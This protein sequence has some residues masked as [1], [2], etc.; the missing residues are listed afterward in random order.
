M[1]E[2]LI[3]LRSDHLRIQ[4]DLE[5]YPYQ[6][7]VSNAIISALLDNLRITAGASEEDVRRLKQVEVAIEQSRQCIAEGALVTLSNG[8][9][10]P[11]Q[12]IQI[13][14]DVVTYDGNKQRV[15]KVE[16]KWSTGEK[17]C[18]E[19]STSKGKHLIATA[20]HRF[21]TPDG[22][23]SINT[24]LARHKDVKF[25]CHRNNPR[26]I[27]GISNRSEF[28][29]LNDPELAK[30]LGYFADGY[31]AVRQTPKFTNNNLDYINEF[32][33]LVFKRFG[34]ATNQRAKGNGYDLHITDGSHAT[35]NNSFINFLREEGLYNKLKPERMVPDKIFDFDKESLALFLNRLIAADGW[36]TNGDHSEIGI[37]ANS[38]YHASQIVSLLSKF[39]VVSHLDIA[40]G[41]KNTKDFYKVRVADYRSLDRL[42]SSIGMV[43]GKEDKC[44]K[45]LDYIKSAKAKKSYVE[46][47]IFWDFITDISPVGRLPTYDIS[48]ADHHNYVANNLVVHNS[49][50]TY[51]VGH[52]CEF[53]LTFLPTLFGRPI[54]IGIFAAQLDQ[55]KISYNILRNGIRK[56]KGMMMI[57]EDEE[58]HIA[59]E[60][61]AR[62]LVLPDGS[63]IIV[64]P[65][66]KISQIEGSTLDLIII[67][68]AQVANDEIVKHSIWPMGK[69]NNAPRVYIGKAGTQINHYYRLCQKNESIKVYFDEVV[70]QRRETYDKTK[71]ARH[72]IYE[73]SV[74]EDIEKQ[75]IDADEIQR[76]Y[77]GK[78]QIGTGQ[79]ITLEELTELES[80]RGLTFHFQKGECFAGIDTA[81][82]PDETWCTILHSTGRMI[83]RVLPDGKTKEYLRERRLLNW[84]VLK[85]ENYQNQFDTLKAFLANYNVIAVAID[86]TGQGDFMGDLFENSTEWTDENSGLYRVKFSAMTKDIMYKN[87]KVSIKQ[88]LLDFPK[89]DS[90]IGEKFREQ[91]LDL[92]QEY[93]G[94]LLSVHHP[95]NAGAHDDAPDSL[96]LAD[97]A[98]AKWY[99]GNEPQLMTVSTSKREIDIEER[100]DNMIK[101]EQGN[102]TDYFPGA[103]W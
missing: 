28:G 13:G 56:A 19:I 52:T 75:G 30:I 94:Q 49:G 25:N 79:F 72:L 1:L 24:G 73:V 50:K 40:N 26:G 57:T 21:L 61:N 37:S 11:I 64:A 68:E 27:V 62:K 16:D 80:E 48:V 76:E 102:V 78:W 98:F 10:K 84:L 55:A 29:Q 18:F 99:S 71:D 46:E 33:E 15:S 69:V 42:L 92:Q 87:L 54:H 3:R 35:G 43:Y 103:D 101:D 82:N 81:K 8:S 74:K 7:K 88:K 14:D 23:M 51:S 89:L 41:V 44:L 34:I 58:K 100:L 83:E 6:N 5:F 9:L 86:S 97:F 17:E 47:D 60:E 2:K 65:I 4:Y 91:M 31:T 85:G 20:D 66:N 32:K 96:A 39:G 22:Y 45:T 38:Y 95:D 63:S 53:I 36:I 59:E 67:D 70:K 77:F 93:K 12:D 90:K